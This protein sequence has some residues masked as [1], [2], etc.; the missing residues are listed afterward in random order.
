FQSLQGFPRKIPTPPLPQPPLNHATFRSPPPTGT[1]ASTPDPLVTSDMALRMASRRSDTRGLGN[2]GSLPSGCS[3]A[4][5]GALDASR[6]DTPT[7]PVG[8][9]ADKIFRYLRCN[10]TVPSLVDFACAPSAH[11]R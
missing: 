11:D 2:A 1:V 4:T 3:R 6:I 8:A 7:A 9:S 5:P 10:D